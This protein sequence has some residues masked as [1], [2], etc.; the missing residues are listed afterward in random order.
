MSYMDEIAQKHYASLPSGWSTSRVKFVAD[1][2]TS[3]V[4]K[5]A[6][7]DEIPVRLCNYTDVYYRDR[8]TADL[9][10]MEGTATKTE[11]EK[12]KL[13]AGQV[14]I[15]KDSESWDDIGIPALV[16]EDIPDAVCGYHLAIFTPQTGSLDGAYLAWLCRADSL[17]DQFK[18]SAN[19]VT[20][21]GLGQYAM[22]NA[23]IAV[24]PLKTQRKIAAFLDEKTAQIDALIEKKQQLLERLAEKRQAI[25]TQAVTKG[26]NPSA[27]MKDSGI[28]WLGQ[29]PAYWEVAAVGYR[30]EVQLGRMLNAERSAGDHPKP[31]LRVFDV[32]WDTINVIDLP[33]MDFP[34]EAQTR[35]RLEPG[36]LLVNEG[37]SY[38]GRAAIWRGELEECYY[39]KALHR[40]RSFDKSQDTA[41]F[42]YFVMEAATTNAVFVAGGNQ[43]TID[44]L[45]AEQLR[46]YRFPFPPLA[47]QELIST[48]LRERLRT[49]SR[50]SSDVELSVEK[51]KEYRSA[52]ITAAVTGQIEGL[53]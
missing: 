27:P 24:P 6:S 5:V 8:I 29:I 52:L 22:K 45:T 7:P 25:I 36:D 30:Y 18:L 38:V 20:R 9:Q 32:Q 31:Y 15:T 4:D 50:I 53:Q 16:A 51:Q 14:L 12:F 3:N 1:I 48:N 46:H 49:I 34:P 40:L 33:K 23:V 11:I 21:F 43:T 35:Y 13:R 28:D 37:G 42:F 39:Q 26:L 17:N 44:H 19:G 10:L 47:E 41:E 2:Q